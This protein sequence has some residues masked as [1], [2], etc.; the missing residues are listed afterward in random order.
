MSLTEKNLDECVNRYIREQD[1]YIKLSEFV[2]EKCLEIVSDLGVRATVQRRAKNPK[3]FMDKL[4]KNNDDKKYTSIENVFEKVSDLAAVRIATY[5]ESDRTKVVERIEKAFVGKDEVSS[6]EVEVK[7]NLP[8][9]EHYRATHCQIYLK[10][11]DLISGNENLRGTTCEIQVC[12]LLAHVFNEIEHDLKYK[13]LSVLSNVER[14]FIDQ[15]GFLTK[16]GD[17][18]IKMLLNA[19][20]EKNKSTKG[21]FTDLHNFIVRMSERFDKLSSFANHANQLF[22]E[23]LLLGLK[24]P[25]DIS[26][27]IEDGKNKDIQLISLIE[28]DRLS[29]FS[30]NNDRIELDRN[31]SDVL[32]VGIL[33]NNLN[34]VIANH[35]PDRGRPS[36]IIQI[37]KLYKLMTEV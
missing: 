16:A 26:R 31:S 2:Y 4:R 13:P 28:F 1:R 27:A 8:G 12:S 37:A 20:D 5:L 33:K 18:T 3:S 32:W 25:E 35:P 9:K 30:T 36:R 10:N 11:E 22:D 14:E 15:L 29:A 6:P 24:T 21:P 23:L 7:D 19:T 34:K 17:T